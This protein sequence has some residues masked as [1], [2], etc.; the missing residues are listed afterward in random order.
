LGNSADENG[1]G[2]Y[3]AFSS[4]V[5][6]TV[7]ISGNFAGSS[8]GGMY[9]VNSASPVLTDVAILGNSAGSYGGGMSSLAPMATPTAVPTTRNSIV[10]GNKAGTSGPDVYN[11]GDTSP[12]F[13]SS[14]VQG[15]GGSGGPWVSSFGTEGDNNN[16]DVDPAFVTWIDPDPGSGW[17]ATD[18]GDYTLDTGSPAIDAGDSSLYPVDADAIRSGLSDAVK[19]LIEDALPYDL[20]GNARIQGAAI[21]MGAYEN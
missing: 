11:Y 15:S 20:A 10:W 3:N 4:P 5:L 21:D 8:G 18:G 2:M 16:L 13:F 12:R 9:N 17:T 1:G 14:I 7:T 19:A 6:T